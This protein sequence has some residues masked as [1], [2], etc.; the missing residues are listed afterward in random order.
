M[1]A[2]EAGAKFHSKLLPPVYGVE[3]V[4]IRIS[5]DGSELDQILTN[6]VMVFG[7]IGICVSKRIMKLLGSEVSDYENTGKIGIS[8]L[9]LRDNFALLRK[10]FD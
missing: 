9:N 7:D 10:Y 3:R 8:Q 2:I 4:N 5:D 1:A 6:V